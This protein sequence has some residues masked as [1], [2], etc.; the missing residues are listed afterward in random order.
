MTDRRSAPQPPGPAGPVGPPEPAEEPSG[1]LSPAAAAFVERLA[2]DL[3]EAG[4]QRMASRVFACLMVADEP[5]LTSADLASRLHVSPAAISGAV[6]YLSQMHLLGRERQPGSRRERYRLNAHIW[7]EAMTGRDVTIKRWQETLRA[8][9]GVVS[10]ES[11]ARERLSEM[12]EFMSFLDEELAAMLERWRQRQP[13]PFG[14]AAAGASGESG[15]VLGD[16][17]GGLGD[18]VRDG[19]ATAGGEAREAGEVRGRAGEA[20]DPAPDRPAPSSAG[21]SGAPAS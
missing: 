13:R 1:E 16:D 8:G 14:G 2:S 5:A 3:V 19:E 17:D 9:L 12:A 20:V 6:R 7:Y 10:T 4:M 15:R 21:R 11:A 18:G